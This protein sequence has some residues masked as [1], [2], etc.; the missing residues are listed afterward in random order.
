M[1]YLKKIREEIDAISAE[2]NLEKG[3]AF[4]LWTLEQYYNLSREDSVDA[5]TDSSSDKRIDAF[6]ETGDSVRIL[7]C[8]LFDNEKK[9]VGEREISVFKGCLDWLRQPEELQRLN[10]P[11]L[12]DCALTF[13]EKW[14]EGATVELHYFALGKFSDGAIRERRVFNNSDSRDRIQ[15]HFHDV[16]D[17]LNLYQANLQSVNPLFD[18]SITL[19]VSK[20]Q[21]FKRQDEGFPALIMSMKG[22]ELAS[23]YA[24]YG[25]R[26]FERNIR[27]FK[28]IRKGSINA[29]IIE[30]VLDQSDRKKFWYYNNGI[31][32][33]C[34][35]FTLDDPV[36]PTKV[37]ISGPQVING[38]QTTACLEEA[39]ER[40]EAEIPDE[41]DVLA[42]FIKAPIAEV[43]LI[44]LYT[45][46]QNPV[47]EAQ[48]KSNDPIQKRLKQDFDNYNPPY[49][50]SIKEGDWKTLS[51]RDKRKYNGRVI[52]MIKAT[53]AVYS[54]LVDP[55]FARR[56]RIE[57]F[58]KKYGEIF[59]KD[60]RVAEILLPWWILTFVNGKIAEY[61]RQE[62]NRL[63][64]NPTTL[65]EDERSAI[66]RKEFLL[67]SNLIILYFTHNLVKK[68]YREYTPEI[69][70]LL[71]NNQLEERI[72]LIFDYI[73][74]V[75][76]FSEKLQQEK[77]LPRFLKN[78]DNIKA[79][80]SE[81]E[82]EIEKDLAQKNDVLKGILPNL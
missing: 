41:I 18:E 28:G 5:V 9:E 36:N 27:L 22:K 61:R 59:K 74:A 12:Y 37:T 35:D 4:I 47:S 77:N 25:D 11:K 62:F 72:G 19:T 21:C 76:S 57:L 68:R 54:F 23:L 46:S 8:K 38:C 3:K 43:E 52:D 2:E 53:Q 44:A 58:S 39:K 51:I 45:N 60:T 48:L 16:D 10:V 20:G 64:L 13:V 67:Y 40:S 17:I 26:L 30:T 73:V 78:L 70:K 66:L 6:M 56:Y 34:S 81:I 31:S 63:K 71:V 75:L 7:Q 42:R 79:L 32:F 80:Y 50:Y 15:M 65:N 24:R 14:N 49:F 1:D 29:K 33:V 82:R 55:A 69:A